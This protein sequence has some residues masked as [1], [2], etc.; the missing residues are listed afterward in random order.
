VTVLEPATPVLGHKASLD[1]FGRIGLIL[2]GGDAKGA[3]Q[4]RAMLAIYE[5]LEEHNALDRVKM[6]AASSI[7]AW[8]ALFWLTARSVRRL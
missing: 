1:R 3:Y 6:V 5:F 4:A 2:A 7:G 8:N